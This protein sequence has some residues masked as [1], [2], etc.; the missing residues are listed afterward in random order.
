[1]ADS[2]DDHADPFSTTVSGDGFALMPR[3]AGGARQLTA[4]SGT[5][6]AVTVTLGAD[7]HDRLCQ[8]GPV[9]VWSSRDHPTLST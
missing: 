5:G 6:A 4:I 9:R 7:R 3:G 2:G 1:M 8:S